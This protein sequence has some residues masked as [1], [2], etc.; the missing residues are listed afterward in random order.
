MTILTAASANR[1]S[2]QSAGR[3]RR[4]RYFLHG[5]RDFFVGKRFARESAM[6]LLEEKLLDPTGARC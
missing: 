1:R 2:A 6:T 5:N 4:P 3:F